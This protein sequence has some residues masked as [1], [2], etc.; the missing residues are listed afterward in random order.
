M[1]S[2]KIFISAFALISFLILISCGIPQVP[3]GANAKETFEFATKHYEDDNYE[4]AQLG[5]DRIKLQYPASIYADDAQYYL[6]EINFSQSKYILAAFNYSTLRRVYPRSDYA[7]LALFKTAMSYYNLSPSFD[8]DQEYTLKAIKTFSEFQAEYPGDSL[9]NKAGEYIDELRNKLAYR[10]FFTAGLYRKIRS[11]KSSLVY[12]QSVIDNYPDTDYLEDAYVG[13]IE[14]L[15]YLGR[16][17]EALREIKKYRDLFPKGEL[18]E[19]VNSI[20]ANL[21]KKEE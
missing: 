16:K 12:Y 3:E 21:G 17:S 10:E 19:Q 7:R 11:S 14:T 13:K 4:A 9:Y 8:R 2:S 20:E 6:A 1:N 15:D 18:K 5:F